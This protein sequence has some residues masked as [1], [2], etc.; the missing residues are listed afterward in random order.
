MLHAREILNDETDYIVLGK[1]YEFFQTSAPVGL[2]SVLYTAMHPHSTIWLDLSSLE[3]ALIFN[4]YR[5]GETLKEYFADLAKKYLL[6]V[7]LLE[8]PRL[9]E[10]F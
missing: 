9:T 3:A 4:Q 5:L 1:P 8:D 2:H 10:T 7:Y 6:N